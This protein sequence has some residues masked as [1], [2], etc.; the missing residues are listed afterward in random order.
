MDGD[1]A[2]GEAIAHDRFDVA[3]EHRQRG[4]GK[5]DMSPLKQ[6]ALDAVSLVSDVRRRGRQID[7]SSIR[8]R[9]RRRSMAG[10]ELFQEAQD[11][12]AVVGQV[13]YP[14]EEALLE[15][16]SEGLVE[17]ADAAGVGIELEEF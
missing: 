1:G 12:T 16:R 2:L 13:V 7:P 14:L 9:W 17:L 3:R 10:P 4:I 8:V 5:H 15:H 6:L 11:L